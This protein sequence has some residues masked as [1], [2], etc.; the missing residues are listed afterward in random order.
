M[1]DVDREQDGEGRGCQEGT[2]PLTLAYETYKACNKAMQDFNRMKAAKT[3]P[4]TCPEPTATY[5]IE[6]FIVAPVL[7]CA[8]F[9]HLQVP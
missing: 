8:F 2:V 7:C 3:W 4:S 5:I 9:P 6:I 1:G